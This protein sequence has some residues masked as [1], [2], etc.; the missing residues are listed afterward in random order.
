MLFQIESAP[1]DI[2]FAVPMFFFWVVISILT[3][4]LINA[5]MMSRKVFIAIS[6]ITILFGGILFGGF[7]NVLVPTQYILRILGRQGL[8]SSLHAAVIV[9]SLILGSSLIVGRI[10]CGFACPIG[11][12]Q[13]LISKINFKSDLKAQEKVKYRIEGSSK[14]ASLV[15]RVFLGILIIMAVFGGILFLETINPLSGFFI[16]RS[17]FTLTLIIPLISLIIVSI[18]S[19]FVYRPWCRYLCP[20]GAFSSLCSRIS[21]KKYRRTEDCTNCGLCEKICPTQEAYAG[22][23][24]NECYFCNR[25]IE[26]CP[27]NAMKFS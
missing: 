10:F 6:V 8:I 12:L 22:S 11:A 16:F 18:V 13:E 14:I 20:F 21:K 24:K 15:R 23:K 25:C 1:F 4:L 26:I 3:I 17:T 2:S 5:E 19:I 9:L 27:D 7:P